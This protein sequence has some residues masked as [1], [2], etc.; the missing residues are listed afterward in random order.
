M[1]WVALFVLMRL[2]A[3]LPIGLI[4]W[5][6]IAIGSIEAYIGGAVIVGVWLAWWRDTLYD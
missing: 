4:V 6:A 1:F 2:A 3:L 5:G